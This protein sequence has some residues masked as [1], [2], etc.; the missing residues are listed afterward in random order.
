MISARLR[1]MREA[2]DELAKHEADLAEEL[3]QATQ[4]KTKRQ[5]PR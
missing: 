3:L 5:A 1:V 4:R 2:V